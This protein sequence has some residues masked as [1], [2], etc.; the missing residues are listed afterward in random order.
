MANYS[1]EEEVEE[2]ICAVEV[3]VGHDVQV[4]SYMFEPLC[5][6]INQIDI[7]RGY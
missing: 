7:G 6:A 1:S 5:T 2:A 3:D 4:Q